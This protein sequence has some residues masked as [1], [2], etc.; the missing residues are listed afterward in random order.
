MEDSEHVLA[1]KGR[2]WRVSL[3]AEKQTQVTITGL[4]QS[5]NP[6]G[7][8]PPGSLQEADNVVIRRKGVLS[9]LPGNEVIRTTT[10]TNFPVKMFGGDR[11]DYSFTIR[12]EQATHADTLDYFGTSGVLV[13]TDFLNRGTRTY[14][15]RFNPGET[16]QTFARDRYFF[17]EHTS[18]VL[19][20]VNTETGALSAL[21]PA[22]MSP[23]AFIGIDFDLP[24]TEDITVIED[25]NFVAYRA[26]F[27]R[28]F[29][30]YKLVSAPTT[31]WAGQNTAGGAADVTLRVQFDPSI[32]TAQ[33][34]DFIEVYKTPQAASL[35]ELGDDFRLCASYELTAADMTFGQ[36]DIVD[37]CQD[38][39][40]GAPLYTNGTQEG[41][42]GLN[43][44]P[45]PAR[46]IVT[47]KDINWYVS[48]NTWPVAVI[49]VPSLFGDLIG[50]TAAEREHGVGRRS[51]TGD[52]AL[53]SHFITN[54]SA[55]DRI[56]LRV[57]QILVDDPG[58]F[59]PDSII[60]SITGSGPYTI[61][62]SGAVSTGSGTGDE[63][64]FA[65]TMEIRASKDGVVTSSTF[66][67]QGS[68]NNLAFRLFECRTDGV[69]GIRL[70]L[71]ETYDSVQDAIT[72]VNFTIWS[73]ISGL[74]DSFQVVVTSG[75]NY[76][77]STPISSFYA[78]IDS[79][80]DTQQNR[81]FFSKSGLPE[82]IAATNYLNV[83][84][85]K[86][87]KLWPTQSS[88]FALCTDG[89]WRIAGDGTNWQVEQLDPTVSLLHPDCVC[90]LNNQIFAWLTDGIAVLGD[91]GSQTI[92]TDAIGPQ[93]REYIETFREQNATELTWGPAMTGDNYRKE[94]WLNLNLPPRVFDDENEG[95]EFFTSYVFNADTGAFTTQSETEIMALA[96]NPYQ[97]RVITADFSGT[98]FRLLR[99][100][101]TTWCRPSVRF[102][103]ITAGDPGYLKQWM[104]VNFQFQ[105]ME[106]ED[107][108]VQGLLLASFD[109]VDVP[110][111]RAVTPVTLQKAHYWIPRRCALKDQL[112]LG[113]STEVLDD[114]LTGTFNFNL[115]GF[116]V[117]YRVASETF[118]K[119]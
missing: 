42:S 106:V 76:S 50:S 27:R 49:N 20:D 47:H 74:W 73:P 37:K 52:V 5:P 59:D 70:L 54:V 112:I 44:M 91:Q 108:F 102:N 69:Y 63:F 111:S 29:E 2:V 100:S 23:P 51:F 80:Q 86:I 56:G 71:S 35:A 28:H 72:G 24:G 19:F 75:Q 79:V 82:A 87:L 78:S 46:D 4:A 15:L 65:D 97:L 8:L 119:G 13:S 68:M 55:A 11:H 110:E 39:A 16:H 92:S 25:N 18:P 57:G 45:P 22:G 114:S 7:N 38:D 17:S 12:K 107:P 33:E 36:V 60:T 31:T 67:I 103:P 109:G 95:Q 21:R 89:L 93:L 99:P 94:V 40:R 66:A 84:A 32:D 64:R 9:P 116:T 48:K 85:G 34:G 113:F 77:P 90:S 88:I 1:S 14:D 30:S 43:L 41:P 96:Y 101:P 117:R 105:E 26:V 3:M 118:K 81:V 83:G 61:G 58:Y 53:G 98:A 104:D 10:T 115:Y 6:Y 62:V